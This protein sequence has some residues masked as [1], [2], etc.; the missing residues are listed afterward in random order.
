MRTTLAVVLSAGLFLSVGAVAGAGDQRGERPRLRAVAMQP[1]VLA[2][3]GFQA[4]EA[5]RLTASAGSTSA[6]RRVQA[7]AAGRFTVQLPEIAVDRCS[8]FFAVAR[9]ARGSLASIKV[10][11]PLCPPALSGPGP[12]PQPRP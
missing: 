9:G 8:S 10:P 7:S 6:N 3:S 5:V 2:G 12:Q 4:R 1:V 11:L